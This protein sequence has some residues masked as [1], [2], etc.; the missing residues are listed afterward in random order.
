MK[1]IKRILTYSLF[2]AV[3]STLSCDK[4]SLTPPIGENNKIILTEITASN[5]SYTVATI[6]TSI[7]NNY[8]FTFEQHGHCWSKEQNPDISDYKTELGICN[9]NSFNSSLL[10]LKGNTIFYIKAYVKISNEIVY[11]EEQIT[12]ETKEY[13]T[14][15]DIDGNIYKTVQ[16]GNQEW[17][18]ENLKVTKYSDGTEINLIESSTDW[19]V[20][21]D[22]AYCYYDNSSSNA[23]T[24]GALYT[25]SAA[26]NGDFSSNN[27]PSDIQGVCPD[28]WHLP[29]YTEWTELTDYLGGANIAGDKLK[30][31]DATNETGFSARFGG[32]RYTDTNN[33]EFHNMN[34]GGYWWCSTENSEYW[35]K[36]IRMNNDNIIVDFE[37]YPKHYGYSVRCLKN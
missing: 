12:I 35:A 28:G 4:E 37:E 7:P 6:T 16:I 33:G 30:E 36:Y 20:Y 21:I 19:S 24:Y 18:A 31:S 22:K 27:N 9:S 1:T 2:I 34:S 29:S 25:W 26:M 13:G 32:G 14:L 11:S 5:I 10:G 15:I 17:M 8:G 23:D 3:I